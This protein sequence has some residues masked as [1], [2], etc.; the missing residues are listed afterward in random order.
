MF[1]VF[2]SGSNLL[3][4]PS[5]TLVGTTTTTR[6]LNY[7]L[8][9]IPFT[10]NSIAQSATTD[11]QPFDNAV[12]QGTPR[13]SMGWS[14]W[15]VGLSYRMTG[16]PSGGGASALNV[17]ATVAG[18]QTW[19]AFTIASG[20]SAASQTTQAVGTTGMSFTASQGLGIQLVTNGTYAP[21]GTRNMS[22]IL[23]VALE[24][25]GA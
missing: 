8:V 10:V 15:I 6:L 12:A 23:W 1:D 5:S 17:W 7:Q 14:G 19:N 24:Y 18:A 21:N 22:A 3:W 20:G 11:M 2:Q 9:P 25:D 4:Q 16:A 13:I